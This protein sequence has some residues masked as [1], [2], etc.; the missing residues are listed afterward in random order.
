MLAA[1]D[2]SAQ[3]ASDSQAGA[4]A[5]AA[6][7]IVPPKLRDNASVSYPAQA[8][9]EH[10]YDH[11]TV[12]LLL[13]IDTDGAVHKASVEEPRGHGFDEAALAAA[14]TLRFEP[15]RRAGKPLAA[16]IRYLFS[17]DPPP[18]A[19]GGSVLDDNTDVALGG[20]QL[21][22]RAA[23]GGVLAAR[24]ATDGSWSVPAVAAGPVHVTVS[25]EHYVPQET[26]I[27][28]VAGKQTQVVFRLAAQP[29]E[30]AR[31]KRADI[32]VTVHGE[33]LPPAVSS[34]TRAEVR[35]IPGAFGDPFRA[36]DA[37]PGVT[38]IVSGLPF[39]YV[40]G[41]P[42]GN[43]G[44][45]LDGVRVPYLYHIAIGP[46]VVQP[47]M[48]DRV[49]LY[50]G[51]YPASFGRFAGGV[52][53]A[54]TTDPRTD[55]HGEGNLRLFDAGA[56]AETG[57]A[58][59]RGTV[60]VGG[61]YSYTAAVVSLLAPKIK[62][63]Y[64]DYQARVSYDLTPH[65]RITAFSFGSYDLLGQQQ[66][67][68]LNILFGTE[69]YRL[70]LSHEHSFESGAVRTDVTLGYDATRLAAQRNAM[71]RSIGIRSQLHK[72]LAHG[73][74]LRA[75]V[76]G[77]LD[78]YT[79][80]QATYSD[81]ES[82]AIKAF[83]NTFPP[84]NDT[85]LGAW[86][87]AVYDV[88]PRFE[89]TPGLRVDLFHSGSASAVGIDP[90]LAMRFKVSDK[91]R[92]THAYGV[93]HQPPSFIVPVPGLSPA[94]LRGGLQTSL[95]TSAGV[96]T[97]IAEGTT[98]SITG[99]YSVFLDMTDSIGSNPTATLNTSADNR[100]L[101]SGVGVEVFV[102]RRLTKHL[103]G[104]LSYTLSRS[105]RSLGNEHFP[106]TF[107][108]THV[109]NGALAYDLGR[110]WRAGTRLTFYTGTPKNPTL[111]GLIAPLR[112]N[113][114]DRYPPFYRVDLRVE[115][116]WQLGKS[117]WLSFVAEMLNVTLNKE[118]FGGQQIGPISV[119]SLGL[120]G[121]F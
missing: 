67:G 12:S 81:P 112:S 17:F 29:A 5:Q 61:R 75:G 84:R 42:P 117:T 100:S 109:A 89:L 88:T 96:E 103:G 14:Q 10:F 91:V 102:K 90:R 34:F 4:A 86:V 3:P 69:F 53:S 104:F 27:E 22:A 9:E 28:L 105:E 32:E 115:K 30:R 21:A 25:L 120:E 64:R 47:G 106:S 62:L 98:A 51:G 44:Y 83:N 52:V 80:D 43:V 58:G 49:D 2:A 97:D 18:P 110:N 76:D 107:D 41:A 36:I 40:R 31:S 78:G 111:R 19:L 56:M 116:R 60:L 66:T 11:V 72:Q 55:P 57:F 26:D 45:F 54:E 23:D 24:S 113:T 121:G 8:L 119:P 38:P 99:F 20:A 33:R 63:D 94:N 65:D 85:A 73:L 74:V 118:N 93:A 13:E 50:P 39:F 82:P 71:D 108:R 46:S 77:A 95:Q 114:P 59:G 70:N 35:Q 68:G 37:L 6:E 7:A 87:D 92:I 79:A 15:A 1:T 48:V 16:R 101:G